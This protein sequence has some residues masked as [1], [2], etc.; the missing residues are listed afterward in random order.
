MRK[1]TWAALLALVLCLAVTAAV[2]YADGQ[3]WP[4]C[5]CCCTWACPCD[6]GSAPTTLKGR[7]IALLPGSV[8]HALGHP[9][10]MV[11]LCPPKK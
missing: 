4:P 7:A 6:V 2:A 3:P 1:R 5:S 8:Q 11:T 9:N 10:G